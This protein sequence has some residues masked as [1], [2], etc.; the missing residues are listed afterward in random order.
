[1]NA[2]GIFLAIVAIITDI[3]TITVMAGQLN[4]LNWIIDN[5]SEEDDN[6]PFLVWLVRGWLIWTLLIESLVL[7]SAILMIF[8]IIYVSDGIF[9]RIPSLAE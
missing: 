3:I 1:M 5:R 4:T 7:L 9:I 6:L 8:G 2:G